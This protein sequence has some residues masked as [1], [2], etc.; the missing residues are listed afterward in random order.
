MEDICVL[1]CK[2][3]PGTDMAEVEGIRSL[4]ESMEEGVV[5]VAVGKC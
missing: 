5:A 4:Q 3:S 2:G 1:E